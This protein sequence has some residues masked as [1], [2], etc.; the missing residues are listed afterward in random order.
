MEIGLAVCLLILGGAILIGGGEI[1]VRGATRLAQLFRISPLVIGLTIVAASTSAPELTVS[2]LGIF[3]K[4]P[5]ADIAVGNVVGSNI[6]N[7]L[8]ILGAAAL[9][10]PL[11]VSVKMVKREIPLMIAVSLL[12]WIIGYFAVTA[13]ADREIAHSL[14]RWGGIL[15]L[16]LLV[17]YHFIILREVKKESNRRIADELEA[18]YAVDS[19]P[20]S[21]FHEAALSAVFLA[22]GLAMLVFGSELFVDKAQVIAR[23]CG[24]SEL[25]ISLT[26]LAVGT[27]LPELVVSVV[28]VIRGNSDIAVGNIVGSNIFNLLGILGVSSVLADGLILSK[29]A[30]VFDLPVMIAVAVFGGYFCV[31][32]RKLTRIEGG[33]LL[34]A[35]VGYV[36]FLLVR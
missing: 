29:D 30:F 21:P 8:L 1:F 22:L 12:L 35:Y 23:F 16:I 3:G 28:A 19:K 34:A 18:N 9:I 27:S 24:L 7:I 20:R 2:L 32:D 4:N 36:A 26:I 11:S 33:F 10:A 25:V 31:T 5:N 17:L 14:P 15:F 13:G 6:S